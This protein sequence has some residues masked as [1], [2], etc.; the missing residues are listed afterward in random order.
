MGARAGGYNMESTGVVVLGSFMSVPPPRV[1]LSALERLLARKLAL[2]GVPALGRVSVEV[3]P[4][5]APYTAFAP[6]TYVAPPRIAG[7]RD[8]DQTSCP[9]N[10]L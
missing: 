1:A 3:T 4:G 7:H 2:H 5:S 6:G 8:G 10:A 9:G